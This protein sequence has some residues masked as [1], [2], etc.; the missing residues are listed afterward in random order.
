MEQLTWT[1][2]V[3]W[4]AGLVM[5][6]ALLFV[7]LWKR[8]Y[9]AVP[10]FTIWIGWAVLT[11]VSLYLGHR[12]GQRSVYAELYWTA[13]FVDLLMQLAVVAELAVLVF[14]KEGRWVPASRARLLAGSLCATLFAAVLAFSVTPAASSAK[15]A[16]YSRASLFET[17]LFTGIFMAVLGAS[18]QLRVGWGDIV[19]REGAG[20][21]LLNVVAFVTDTLHVYWRTAEHFGDLEH[22]RMVVYL[23]TLAYWIGAFWLSG[24]APLVA[25]EK[26]KKQL[27]EYRD[28]LE[29]SRIRR[30]I[31]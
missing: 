6:A 27:S 24:N 16:L 13:A 20:F 29:S 15:D 10:A 22:L 31:G 17:V 9:R 25:D 3:L 8:R 21:L 23:A 1:A 7:L 5:N 19:V 18:Q 26:T 28:R 30:D 2:I 12:H 4:A 14:R 11:T